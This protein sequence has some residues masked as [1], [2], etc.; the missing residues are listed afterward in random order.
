MGV[1]SAGQ[2]FSGGAKFH[3]YADLMD[4]ISRHW[5]DDM[6]AEHAIGLGVR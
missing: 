1:A 4:Q 5:T 6:S 3:R 2:I